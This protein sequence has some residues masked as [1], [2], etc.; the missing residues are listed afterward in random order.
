MIFMIFNNSYNEHSASDQPYL[1]PY[2]SDYTSSFVPFDYS[3]QTIDNYILPFVSY[4]NNDNNIMPAFAKDDILSSFLYSKKESLIEAGASILNQVYERIDLKNKNLYELDQRICQAGSEILQLDHFNLG[5]NGAVDKRVANVEKD[6]FSFER[7]K[8]FEQVACWRDIS[9]L[10]IQLMDIKQNLDSQ[11][12][13]E[14][15]IEG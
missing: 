6:L 2:N 8:R 9:R 10:Q 14:K 4:L 7:E 11:T 15:L 1:R 3:R 5:T 13:R 12:S